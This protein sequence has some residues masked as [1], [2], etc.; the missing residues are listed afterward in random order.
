LT[1]FYRLKE[2]IIE[3]KRINKAFKIRDELI[4][5]RINPM[6]Q[7]LK[8]LEESKAIFE[9][10]LAQIHEVFQQCHEELLMSNEDRVGKMISRVDLVAE[11]EEYEE[12]LENLKSY[13]S[14]DEVEFILK[15]QMESKSHNHKNIR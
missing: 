11:I 3:K 15:L 8:E 14:A 2:E 5:L 7:E 10:N 12:L 13:Y 6:K 9:E 1:I 4:N